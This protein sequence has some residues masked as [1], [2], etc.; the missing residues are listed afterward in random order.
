MVFCCCATETGTPLWFRLLSIHIGID[1]FQW[2]IFKQFKLCLRTIEVFSDW[3]GNNKT[4]VNKN[5]AVNILWSLNYGGFSSKIA[6]SANFVG[7]D[8]KFSLTLAAS[9]WTFFF[10][11]LLI[12]ATETTSNNKMQKSHLLETLNPSIISY[13]RHF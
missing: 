2:W 10:R 3:N 7:R 11:N 4:A 12:W 8:S 5:A 6:I 9:T 13:F 1:C